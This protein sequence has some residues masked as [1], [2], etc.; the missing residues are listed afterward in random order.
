M[1]R[2]R[3][4]VEEGAHKHVPIWTSNTGKENMAC[5]RCSLI[6]SSRDSNKQKM[7][8]QKR[9]DFLDYRTPPRL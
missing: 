4:E 3:G 2:E 1:G 6:L 8:K 9:R 7:R 5:L